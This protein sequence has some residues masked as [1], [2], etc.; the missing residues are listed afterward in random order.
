MVDTIAVADAIRKDKLGGV[1]LDVLE[2]ETELKKS[3]KN[4]NKLV[5]AEKYLLK[6]DNAVLTAHNAFNS[7]ESVYR[8]LDETI[9]NI[10]GKG[11]CLSC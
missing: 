4:S 3:F 8:L 2:N 11:K 6:S 1:G 5:K 7:K 10:K 9:Q